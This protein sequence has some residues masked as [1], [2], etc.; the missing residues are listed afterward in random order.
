MNDG[1]PAFARPETE[2]EYGSSGMTVRQVYKGLIAAGSLA[3]SGI[4]TDNPQWADWVGQQAD[5]LIR[6]DEEFAQ[7][8][9]DK[10][11]TDG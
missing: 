7:K 9:Q 11:N 10:E 4:L 3:D 1:G 2:E 6:E 8:Q 5:D